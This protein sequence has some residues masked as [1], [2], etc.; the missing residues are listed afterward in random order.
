MDGIIRNLFA[1]IW[2]GVSALAWS[3]QFVRTVVAIQSVFPSIGDRRVKYRG[4]YMHATTIDR[5]VA[6]LLWKYGIMEAYELQ[7]AR[8]LIRPGM[9]V[10]D[11]GSNIGFHALEFA[12]WAGPS[13]HVDAFEPAPENYAMLKRNVEASGLANVRALDLAVSNHSGEITLYLNPANRGDHRMAGTSA[14]RSAIR[15][16]ATTLDERYAAAGQRVDFV[17]IDVQGAEY[18]VLAG[19]RQVFRN[20]PDLI[21]LV[22]FSPALTAAT[23]HTPDEFIDLLGTL[24]RRIQIMDHR[25]K[26]CVDC[27]LATLRRKAGTVRQLDLLL[28]RNTGSLQGNL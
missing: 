2:K 19:M 12:R 28:T 6:L 14:M 22:E 3:P 8:S 20:N 7:I 16:P 13:G 9:Q 18:L 5:L 15:V 26:Q 21:L 1:S 11:V 27:D 4:T 17:K 23:G 10:L 25:T 24:N